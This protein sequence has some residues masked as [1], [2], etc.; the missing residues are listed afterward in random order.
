MMEMIGLLNI[1]IKNIKFLELNINRLSGHKL[2][3]FL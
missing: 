3:A 2:F 1:S